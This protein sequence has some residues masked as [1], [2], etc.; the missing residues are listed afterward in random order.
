MEVIRKIA[1]QSTD[2]MS[3]N[4]F[5]NMVE[6]EQGF[7]ATK[8]EIIMFVKEHPDNMMLDENDKNIFFF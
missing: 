7:I 8:S 5:I 2:Q 3:V 1:S 4:D 6:K